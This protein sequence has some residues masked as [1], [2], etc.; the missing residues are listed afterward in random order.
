LQ[1]THSDNEVEWKMWWE[2]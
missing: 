2:G 1:E